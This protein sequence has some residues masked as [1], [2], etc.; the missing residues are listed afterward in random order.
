MKVYEDETHGDQHI[1]L[2]KGDL[3]GDNP[4]LVRIC[5]GPMLDI[6]R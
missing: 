4:V 5:N 3:T 2:I 1:V 6:R